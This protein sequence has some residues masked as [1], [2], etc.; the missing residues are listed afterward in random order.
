MSNGDKYEGDYNNNGFDG[1]G[2]YFFSN[3][4]VYDGDWKEGV[5]KEG[6]ILTKLLDF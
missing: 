1:K 4:D 2:I 6:F 3:G 5:K